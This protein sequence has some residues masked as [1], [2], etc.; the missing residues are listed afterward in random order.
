MSQYTQGLSTYQQSVS[1]DASATNDPP[2]GTNVGQAYIM[3]GEPASVVNETYRNMLQ[4]IFSL[5][6]SNDTAA[7]DKAQKAIDLVRIM[8]QWRQ[9]VATGSD[10]INGFG[11]EPFIASQTMVK[12]MDFLAIQMASSGLTPAKIIQWAKDAGVPIGTVANPTSYADIQGAL[13]VISA[14]VDANPSALSTTTA[15]VHPDL[16]FGVWQTGMLVSS[17]KDLVLT[18]IRS[19]YPVMSGPLD[20]GDGTGAA[21]QTRYDALD[22]DPG[23]VSTFNQLIADINA[24][25]TA[26]SNESTSTLTRADV[27]RVVNDMV[28]LRTLAGGVQVV[29]QY[30]GGTRLARLTSPMLQ[31][32]DTLSRSL[33]AVGLVSS[34]VSAFNAALPP[35]AVDPAVERF[36][37]WI[38]PAVGTDGTTS[39]SI[40]AVGLQAAQTAGATSG[41]MQAMVEIQYVNAGANMLE[42][43]LQDLNQA[44]VAVQTTAQLLGTLQQ[45]HNYIDVNAPVPL[46]LQAY[47]YLKPEDQGKYITIVKKAIFDLLS[48]NEKTQLA[49]LWGIDPQTFSAADITPEM[50]EGIP[51]LADGD[52]GPLAYTGAVTELFGLT[53]SQTYNVGASGGIIDKLFLDF[54]SNVERAIQVY[55]SQ[56]GTA[57]VSNALR[58]AIYNAEKTLITE[59]SKLAYETLPKANLDMTTTPPTPKVP[60]VVLPSQINALR[61]LIN[62]FLNFPLDVVGDVDSFGNTRPPASTLP[63]DTPQQ[64][65]VYKLYNLPETESIDPVQSTQQPFGPFTVDSIA[66]YLLASGSGVINNLQSQL[67]L[68]FDPIG[69]NV[70]TAS[71]QGTLPNPALYGIIGNVQW[72]ATDTSL[73]DTINAG[74]QSEDI[75]ALTTRVN[76]LFTNF[77]NALSPLSNFGA[78]KDTFLAGMNSELSGLVSRGA[79]T[80]D[81]QIALK[82]TLTD[83]F[84]S[85]AYF[86]RHSG[87]ISF[88]SGVLPNVTSYTSTGFSIQDML[89]NFMTLVSFNSPVLPGF[90]NAIAQ[91]IKTF[92]D[93]WMD[94]SLNSP[95]FNSAGT[96]NYDGYFDAAL[97]HLSSAV[98]SA[99]STYYPT[100]T[101]FFS[102]LAS[103]VSQLQQDVLVTKHVLSQFVVYPPPYKDARSTISQLKNFMMRS[104][105]DT[106]T[107]QGIKGIFSERA[108]ITVDADSESISYDTLTAMGM[109]NTPD[110]NLQSVIVDTYNQLST[111]QRKD[112]VDTLK[113]AANATAYKQAG[114]YGDLL[115]FLQG[116]NQTY[117]NISITSASIAN[118]TY[119]PIP[120]KQFKA[121]YDTI[122]S[123]ITK[124][125]LSPADMTSPRLSSTEFD[126]LAQQ[127]YSMTIPPFVKLPAGMTMEDVLNKILST[128]AQLAQQLAGLELAQKQQQDAT[129]GTTS[130]PIVDYVKSV[131][132]D[133]QRIPDPTAS[134]YSLANAR[135][136]LSSWI[137]DGMQL[138]AN[139]PSPAVQAAAVAS[140]AI[141]TN[142]QTAITAATNLNGTQQQTFQKYMTVYSEFMQSASAILTA[143]MQIMRAMITGIRG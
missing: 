71:G 50:F 105:A 116:P 27:E 141:Q 125:I 120:A 122:N 108:D 127:I 107:G 54:R 87:A 10:Y 4:M 64:P 37:T 119:V 68:L 52:T 106:P 134:T 95:N 128:R 23:L 62:P 74:A 135:A 60:A 26:H 25:V 41:S 57:P 117:P 43:Q 103:A 102:N 92:K 15:T 77:T 34:S 97:D 48:G 31:A 53:G 2:T 91:A 75:S 38:T 3:A 82:S 138:N 83:Y 86:T 13:S 114:G 133:L 56:P 78:A 19:T 9:S 73:G 51:T 93:E 123:T 6:Q 94:A 1:Y 140:G 84:Y 40:A 45:I 33:N 118:G 24:V 49:M 113:A 126:D 59:L 88:G 22:I 63:S 136:A 67:K 12:T 104:Y 39:Q 28:L 35:A 66:L 109:P 14:A 96:I 17:N 137:L 139:D 61:Q 85:D 124:P 42:K 98:Q 36:K 7:G 11:T 46:A 80:L 65:Y 90:G 130:T 129:G 32:I 101:P 121:Y 110:F 112:F 20:T 131:L 142:L 111:D 21:L 132:Q 8:S 143:M 44:L 76:T 89:N 72:N 55:L 16:S 115:S 81:Q 69:S 58:T 29:D 100:L 70:V 5:M 47:S 18:Q 30:Q 79:L 99:L